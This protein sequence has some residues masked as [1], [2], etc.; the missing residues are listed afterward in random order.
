MFKMRMNSE[1][2]NL[3]HEIPVNIWSSYII[4][5]CLLTSTVPPLSPKCMKLFP[6]KK[7]ITLPIG[8]DLITFEW[9]YR[10]FFFFNGSSPEQ[11]SVIARATFN[12]HWHLNPCI[13]Q[14]GQCRCKPK[15]IFREQHLIKSDPWFQAPKHH[16]VH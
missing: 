2:L 3:W 14:W 13:W 7:K 12:K 8:E 16:T 11:A 1:M 4:L 5:D 15:L 10:S 9:N 6:K